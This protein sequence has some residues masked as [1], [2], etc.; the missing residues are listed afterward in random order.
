[1]RKLAGIDR[2]FLG[3]SHPADSETA[4]AG[5]E[6]SPWK[7]LT[8]LKEHGLLTEAEFAAKQAALASPG[9]VSPPLDK[10]TRAPPLRL[11]TTLIPD[12][13]TIPTPESTPPHPEPDSAPS[14]SPAPVPAIPLDAPAPPP[15]Q[16]SADALRQLPRLPTH[17]NAGPGNSLVYRPPEFQSLA[18]LTT[19][20]LEASQAMASALGSRLKGPWLACKDFED[21][22]QLYAMFLRLWRN[23]T[24]RLHVYG[25]SMTYGEGCCTSCQTRNNHCSWSGQFADY[26]RSAFHGQVEL[27][28]R[29]RGGC[30]MACALPDMVLSQ[31]TATEPM[32]VMLLDFGQ[33]GWGS[34]LV[35]LTEES[36]SVCYRLLTPAVPEEFVRACHLFLPKTLLVVLWPL[37][38]KPSD[39]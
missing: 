1:M 21:Y 26:L 15:I 8:I 13:P 39:S 35:F 32:D 19:E 37:G 7:A 12:P 22:P 31:N 6:L 3:V 2:S 23:Q 17:T 16:L 10:A 4:P 11:G 33:N 14:P 34:L 38:Q 29:A 9:A 36:P 5:E 20:A 24:V 28:N 18:A 27:D 30:D 25:G